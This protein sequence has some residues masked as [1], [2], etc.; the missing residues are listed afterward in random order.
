MTSSAASASPAAR[1][2]VTEM[3][4]SELRNS[5]ELLALWERSA[6]DFMPIHEVGESMHDYGLNFGKLIGRKIELMRKYGDRM[7][8]IDPNFMWRMP[9]GAEL[10]EED[11]LGY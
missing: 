7:P 1:A 8:R 2:L 3:V 9:E 11:Y 5:E 6:V 10:K 4:E